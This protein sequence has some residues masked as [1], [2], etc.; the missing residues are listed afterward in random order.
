MTK[1]HDNI[2]SKIAMFDWIGE[3]IESGTLAPDELKDHNIRVSQAGFLEL[4]GKYLIND[5]KYVFNK[6]YPNTLHKD[7]SL[8]Q[9]VNECIEELKEVVRRKV[10]A[11]KPRKSVSQENISLKQTNSQLIKRNEELAAQL[12]ELSSEM[13]RL[14]G[15]LS[16]YKKQNEQQRERLITLEAANSH[17]RSV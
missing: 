6:T 8:R 13:E 9:E 14:R 3:C 11:K 5:K 10:K 2:K 15:D 12:V 4:T 17:L 16:H 1:Q 7:L